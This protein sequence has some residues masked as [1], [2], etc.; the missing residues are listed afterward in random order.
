MNHCWPTYARRS[1][2]HLLHARDPPL[3]A[4]PQVKLNFTSEEIMVTNLQCVR[5][6]YAN[7]ASGVGPAAEQEIWHDDQK[8]ECRNI[9]FTPLVHSMYA[10]HIR[11]WLKAFSRDSVILLRFDDLVLRPVEVLQTL[12]S[13]LQITR[14]PPNFKV[15]LGRENFTTID[16]LLQSGAV[17]K[18]SLKMLQD[19]FAPHDAMLHKMFPGQRFY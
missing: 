1:T 2:P 13:F 11:R 5:P 6:C 14:F 4:R 10:L 18:E 3:V 16:R 9:Y 7:D 19:F 12:A 15:E 8:P 17:T